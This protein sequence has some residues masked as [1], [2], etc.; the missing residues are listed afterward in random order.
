LFAQTGHF[1]TG[2]SWKTRYDG[3]EHHHRRP[4]PPSR[5]QRPHRREGE[6]KR[7]QQRGGHEHPSDVDGQTLGR[8]ERKDDGARG[9]RDHHEEQQQ[10]SGPFG[11]HAPAWNRLGELQLE[12]AARVV[13]GPARHRGD[14]Q[15]GEHALRNAEPDQGQQHRVD[16][17][18]EVAE[19]RRQSRRLGEE[20]GGQIDDVDHGERTGSNPGDPQD[21]PDASCPQTAQHGDAQQRVAGSLVHRR[22]SRS[23]ESDEAGTDVTTREGDGGYRAG[24]HRDHDQR[25]RGH[26]VER[27]SWCERVGSVV[28]KEHREVGQWRAIEARAPDAV[29]DEQD[30]EHRRPRSRGCSE[31][32]GDLCDQGADTEARQRESPQR[33]ALP[34]ESGHGCRGSGDHTAEPASE[35]GSDDDRGAQHR[36][37]RAAR[38]QES[39]PRHAGRQPCLD[40]PSILVASHR[41]A[42]TEQPPGREDDRE[43]PVTAPLQ[44]SGGG[45]G[46]DRQRQQPREL[47]AQ[48]T[49]LES[50]CFLRKPRL[51]GDQGIDGAVDQN[52]EDREVRQ[53]DDADTMQ[54]QQQA[55]RH[56]VR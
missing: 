33:G 46:T 24:D 37:R 7:H 32:R 41:A 17:A 12:D 43:H 9:K 6:R 30:H 14:R 25:E 35:S 42:S 34:H 52:V 8:R 40:H 29:D 45:V 44:V 5:E 18:G 2:P 26:R 31:V 21:R 15:D 20:V 49:D 54:A 4:R 36:K 55:W 22:S 10:L 51:P 50:E 39:K 56:Q 13:R 16:V 38:E 23:T 3:R 48:G 53:R 28:Q 11:E 47:D 19:V 1:S 27:A